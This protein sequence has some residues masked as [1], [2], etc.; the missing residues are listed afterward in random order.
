MKS[1]I[2]ADELPT[3]SSG[4]AGKVLKVNS[5]E[6]GVE[7][8]TVGGGSSYTAGDGID[9]T[10]DVISRIGITLGEPFLTILSSGNISGFTL[11]N[12]A[13][14]CTTVADVASNLLKGNVVTTP[15]A[16]GSMS[17]AQLNEAM[18][19]N[20][21][22]KKFNFDGSLSNPVTSTNYNASVTSSVIDYSNI[23]C[24]IMG[25]DIIYE[26]YSLS[27]A[28]SVMGYNLLYLIRDKQR[29]NWNSNSLY[30]VLGNID[31][32]LS[33]KAEYPTI[34]AGDAGKVLAVN[35]GETG[36]AWV[37][38]SSSPIPPCPTTEDSTFQ[39]QCVVSNGVATYSWVDIIPHPILTNFWLGLN[40]TEIIGTGDLQGE[41]DPDNKYV[42]TWDGTL[43]QAISDQAEYSKSIEVECGE[44]QG[45]DS[46]NCMFSWD[47]EE[48]CWVSSDGPTTISIIPE[49]GVASAT[50]CEVIVVFDPNWEPLTAP[51]ILNIVIT[52]SNEVNIVD[53]AQGGASYEH[54]VV[55]I[56][57]EIGQDGKYHYTLGTA[58]NTLIV[59]GNDFATANNPYS[60]VLTLPEGNRGASDASLTSSADPDWDYTLEGGPDKFFFK[61]VRDC[62]YVAELV[63]DPNWT[64]SE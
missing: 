20:Y 39:L 10:N 50:S 27:V 29:T 34:A 28:R 43:S 54:P 24:F 17:P 55:P 40:D 62:E 14:N 38:Q 3:I 16:F 51:D 21:A 41:V 57:G 26:F 56:S 42:F 19:T 7:W 36:V 22:V 18:G 31:T 6:T 23:E 32:L 63:F 35:S 45:G 12:V 47:S 53:T 2:P 11:G 44:Y 4:D 52:D 58:D 49:G 46:G 60:F 13:V 33:Q 37:T 5:G 48:D 59:D 8:D 64:P 1:D 15:K 9:I 25:S 61:S 30:S